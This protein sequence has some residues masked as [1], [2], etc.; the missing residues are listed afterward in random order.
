MRKNISGKSPFEPIIGFSRAVRVGNAVYLS[1]TA[2]AGAKERDAAGQT[3]RIFEISAKALAEA[4]ASLQDVVR[5]RIYLVHA[6]DWE[7]VGLV[8]GEYFSDVRPAATMVVVSQLLD[9]AWRVEIEMDA[10][11]SDTESGAAPGSTIT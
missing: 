8:H 2:P 3:R 11:I 9:P 7:A 4:G 10:V 1:G 5:T 6:E